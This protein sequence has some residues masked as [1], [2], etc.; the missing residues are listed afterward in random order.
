MMQQLTK[1]ATTDLFNV[2]AGNG[3]YSTQLLELCHCIEGVVLYLANESSVIS[4]A[5]PS[6][7]EFL[8]LGLPPLIEAF[9]R[10]V[11]LRFVSY[12]LISF[13]VDSVNLYILTL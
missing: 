5:D 13:Y 2:I 8:K 4:L 3:T 9:M 11:S 1:V 6:L 12:I 7:K 10:R